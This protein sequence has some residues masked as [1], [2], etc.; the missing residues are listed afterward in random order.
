MGEKRKTYTYKS[1][2]GFWKDICK[3]CKRGCIWGEEMGG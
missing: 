2:D 3:T 1:V